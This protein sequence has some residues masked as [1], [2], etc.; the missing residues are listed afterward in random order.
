MKQPTTP[1]A[2]TVTTL[3]GAFRF[4]DFVLYRD[5]VRYWTSQDDHTRA[6]RVTD[7]PFTGTVGYRLRDLETGGE[8]YGADSRY[9]RL[10]PPEECMRDIDAAAL[11]G[12]AAA[13][14][15]GAAAYLRT[16]NKPT[17]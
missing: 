16:T 6:Y 9:M 3:R 8:V 11:E 7:V 17:P 10:L 2:E 1:Q 13:L 5:P 14:E 4:G 12:D 15:S